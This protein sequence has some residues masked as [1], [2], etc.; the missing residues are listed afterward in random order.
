MNRLTGILGPNKFDID[1]AL[2]ALNDLRRTLEGEAFGMK[3]DIDKEGRSI[4]STINDYDSQRA[5]ILYQYISQ[6]ML[7]LNGIDIRQELYAHNNWVESYKIWKDGLSGNY[8]DN[9]NNFGNRLLNQVTQIALE[10]VQNAREAGF[11]RIRT[12]RD[13]TEELKRHSGYNPFVEHT[14][15]NQTSLYDGM[16]YFSQN[17]DL[18]FRNPWN[19]SDPQVAQ[20]S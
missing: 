4:H 5:Q 6:A 14:Y 10:G 7:E 13:K 18:L 15:G 9:A 12:L 3:K 16:T 2:D 17:G 11:A 1:I 19:E 8:I 20:M